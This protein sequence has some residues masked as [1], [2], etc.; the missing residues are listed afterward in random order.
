M[1]VISDIMDSLYS[2]GSV[3][4]GIY[5][6]GE[7][8]NSKSYEVF[9]YLDSHKVEYEKITARVSSLSLFI[10][11][12]EHN[13]KTIV[14]DDI[15]LD[16]D[17]STELL[18][19]ALNEDGLVSWHTTSGAFPDDLESSFSFKGKIIIITNEGIKEGHRHYPL[20]SRCYSLEHNLDI[21][22]YKSIAELMCKG[23][24]VDFSK[25]SPH[26]SLF[27]KHRDLRI[28]NKAMDFVLAGKEFMVKALFEV[29]LELKK[30]DELVKLYDKKS[31][32]RK[33][34]C[35]KFDKGKRTFYR[36]LKEYSVK[37]SQEKVVV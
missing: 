18:K 6:T 14:M 12:A 30:I 35:K 22:E 20:L 26:I 3:T 24:G 37:V 8:G 27:L 32:I 9:K 28:V 15:S 17:I 11:L 34:W 36:K 2:A 19:G 1:S 4:R 7:A 29:D 16:K 10:L 13:N 5:L 21:N 25:L 33:E 23:R 31:L